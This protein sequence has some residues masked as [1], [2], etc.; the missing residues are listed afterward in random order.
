MKH[1]LFGAALAA[2]VAGSIGPVA[3][4]GAAPA[5]PVTQGAAPTAGTS[6]GSVTL[7]QAVLADGQKLAAGTYQVRLSADVPKPAVGQSP[8]AER[9]VEFVRGGKVAG[10]EVASVVPAAEIGQVAD[11]PRPANGG[12]RVELLK[13]ND[14]VRVWI[15][16]GG[17]NYILHLPP[18]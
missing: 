14:Y 2:V 10:R 3:A 9:Y 16:R 7:R 8:D 17:T 6:L 1:L 5:R 11:G 18:A 13:G 15:N 12:S 4:Q